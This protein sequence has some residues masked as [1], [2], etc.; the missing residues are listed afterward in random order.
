MLIVGSGCAGGSILNQCMPSVVTGQ[1][2]RQNRWDKTASGSAV[3]WDPNNANYIGKVDYINPTAFTVLNAGTCSTNPATTG[4]YHT[5]NGQAYNVC[6][7]PEDYAVGTAGR[8]APIKGLYTQPT[9]N[10]DMS[11]RRTFPI[12]ERCKL[13][14]QVD[15]TNVTNHVVLSGPG[16]LTVSTTSA[17]AAGNFGV[18]SKIGN[19]PRDV[20]GG[21]RISW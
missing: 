5:F 17:S 16:N 19:S 1:P 11:L 6:N 20:Q 10:I 14:L 15:M 21:A 2:G 4:A 18:V 3:S 13:E 12:H 9:F 7:G 8:V